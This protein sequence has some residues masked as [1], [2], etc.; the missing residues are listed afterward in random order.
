MN[1]G[2]PIYSYEGTGFIV[3]PGDIPQREGGIWA[4][5]LQSTK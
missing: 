1:L 4:L 3:R 2:H 5:Q